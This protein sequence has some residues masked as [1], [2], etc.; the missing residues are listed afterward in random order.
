[1][2]LLVALI[3]IVG[4]VVMFN[5]VYGLSTFKGQ[6]TGLAAPPDTASLSAAG[7]LASAASTVQQGT[8]GSAAVLPPHRAS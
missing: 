2:K 4:V 8:A 6:A 7:A 3:I 5:A 1:V